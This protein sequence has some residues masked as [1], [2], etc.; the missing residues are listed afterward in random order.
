MG[1]LSVDVIKFEAQIAATQERLRV[2][3][4]SLAKLEVK[5]AA[6]DQRAWKPTSRD[7][8]TRLAAAEQAKA[9]AMRR[10]ADDAKEALKRRAWEMQDHDIKIRLAEVHVAAK[11]DKL[12]VKAPFNGRVIYRHASPGAALSNGPVLVMSPE[13]GRRF[14]FLLPDDQ[15]AARRARPAR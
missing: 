13:D 1:G 6:Q 11:M 3:K 10:L 7:A 2:C 4:E 5:A 9:E 12:E 14:H 15:V 8:K